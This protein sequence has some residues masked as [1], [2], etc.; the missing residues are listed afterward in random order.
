[1]TINI[2]STNIYTAAKKMIS[3]E[4][5]SAYSED[6]QSLYDA[7]RAVAQDEALLQEYLQDAQNRL[8]T[9]FNQYASLV[10]G[11]IVLTLPG[12]YLAE[13]E[14]TIIS[15]AG[16]FIV[17]HIIKEWLAIV[18]PQKSNVY[19]EKMEFALNDLRSSIYART[20]PSKSTSWNFTNI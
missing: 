1:M 6:G 18:Y 5:R 16:A 8:M 11:D 17:A 13:Q 2:N 3:F 10:D 9:E 7:V 15:L 4:A 12:E 20:A 19:M 14:S